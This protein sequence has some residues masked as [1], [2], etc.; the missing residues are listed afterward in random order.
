MLMLKYPLIIEEAAN[1]YSPA[2]LSNYL[3]ELAKTFNKFYHDDPILKLEDADRLNFRL[4][5]CKNISGIISSG[6]S[7]LGIEVPERM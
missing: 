5:I 4:L 7:L 1:A 2:L 6:M 3:Y